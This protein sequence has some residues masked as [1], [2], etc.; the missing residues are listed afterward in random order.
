MAFATANLQPGTQ[1]NK[2]VLMGDWSGSAGDASGSLTIGGGRV[3]QAHFWDQGSSSPKEWTQVDV[4]ESSGSCVVSIHNHR[5]VTN[6]RFI[7]VF[8]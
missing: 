8:A 6:G 2:R 1:G 5:N 4:A 7:I 3:Y